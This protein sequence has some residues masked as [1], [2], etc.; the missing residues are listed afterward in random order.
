MKTIVEKVVKA[1]ALILSLLS[2]GF[3]LVC[4]LFLLYFTGVGGVMTVLYGDPVVGVLVLFTF[5]TL[6]MLCDVMSERT[7]GFSLVT[8]HLDRNTSSRGNADI[9]RAHDGSR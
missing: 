3:S 1:L 8:K 7:F 5:V 9:A 2:F 6:C 4:M